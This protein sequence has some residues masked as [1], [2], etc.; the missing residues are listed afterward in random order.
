MKRIVLPLIVLIFL[1]SCEKTDKVPQYPIALNSVV[2]VEYNDEIFSAT[3]FSD[4][5]SVTATVLEPEELKGLKIISSAD[6]VKI[7]NGSITLPY[8]NNVL[9]RQC[10]LAVLYDILSALNLQMPEFGQIAENMKA[11]FNYSNSICSVTVNADDGLIEEIITGK[12]I[13]KF[14]NEEIVT[15]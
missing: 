4:E 8:E 5:K 3:V 10:P 15:S 7:Q 2:Q 1:A 9:E 11:E 6:G 13:F 14:K 12:N